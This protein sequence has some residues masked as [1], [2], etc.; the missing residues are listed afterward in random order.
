MGT[1]THMMTAQEL[2]ELQDDGHRHELIKGELIDD[3]VVPCLRVLVS[4][5]FA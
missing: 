3:D 5:I 2:L 1:T 4:Q